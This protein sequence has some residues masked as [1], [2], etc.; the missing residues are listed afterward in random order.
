MILKQIISSNPFADFGKIIVGQRF[1]GRQYAIEAIHNRVLGENYGNIAIIGMPRIG[2]SSLAWKAL[3]EQ[4]E[5]LAISKILVT[6]INVGEIKSANDLFISLLNEVLFMIED[7]IEPDKKK[8]L[9]II[10]EIISQT[11]F[12]IERNSY[13]NR[14]FRRIRSF[15]YRII[16]ILDEF[17]NVSNFFQLSDFQFLREL[18]I[19]PELKICLVTVSRR[20]IQELEL[21]NGVIS[22]FYGV[23]TDLRLGLFND[24]DIYEYW[25]K[26][27][28]FGIKA[29]PEYRAKVNY[30]VGKHPF[31]IDLFNYHVFN[32]VNRVENKYIN[33]TIDTI[34]D[35]LKLTLFTHFDSSLN[36]IKNE[37][38]YHKAF[39]I[40]FGPIYDVSSLDE[41]KLIKYQFIKKLNIEDKEE[42]LGRRV[43]LITNDNNSYICYSEYLTEYWNLKFSEIDF[44]PIWKELE[45]EV[46]WLIKEFL[47]EQYGENW[48][49]QFICSNQ[50]N[51]GHL[52]AIHRLQQLRHSSVKKF[53]SLASKHLIDYTLTR[54]MY[55]HFISNNWD[56]FNKIFNIDS[57]KELSKKFNLLADVRNPMAHNNNEFISEYVLN[58]SKIYCK[59]I[60]DYIKCWQKNSN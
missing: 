13:I 51:P 34:E 22:N 9:N 33:D 30:F 56:W 4:K 49:E 58:E 43:G 3:M 39:Q 29:L 7:I 36:L 37:K 48:E 15:G 16:F 57:K 35:E 19:N 8:Q 5:E 28:S 47:L 41:Q 1:I 38:L 55:G 25:Q 31:L 18:S 14:F 50:N 23:F 45:K 59:Q 21:E 32:L 12:N 54:D 20:T 27:E 6:R 11:K 10:V 44:W 52:E 42:L 40:V 26:I 46:R 17:D 2:K 24:E 53:G 60:I